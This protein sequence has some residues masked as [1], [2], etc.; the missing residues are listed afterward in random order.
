MKIGCGS[1]VFRK[2]SLKEALQRI[3]DAKYEYIEIQATGPFCPH[4]DVDNDD[5]KKISEM[6]RNFG[7]REITALWASHGAIIPD[8]LSME[9]IKK[10]I[11]WAK[12][13][14]IP[15]VHLSDGF[16]PEEINEDEAWDI[17]E[18]RLSKLLETAE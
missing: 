4:V 13:A 1:V 2:L 10:S 8:D 5:P 12:E 15:I 6:I 3:K 14:G 9:Y 7:F 11:L 17:F 16:K 18:S